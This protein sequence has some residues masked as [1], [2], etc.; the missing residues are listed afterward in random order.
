MADCG[1]A[2]KPL[3][4]FECIGYEEIGMP[5][6]LKRGRCAFVVA[7]MIGAGL[8]G[9]G[10]GGCANVDAED[11]ESLLRCHH[12]RSAGSSRAGDVY[13]R[14]EREARNRRER[15]CL[16]DKPITAG[17]CLRM[18]AAIIR[19][20]IWI[21][22]KTSSVQSVRSVSSLSRPVEADGARRRLLRRQ[23]AAIEERRR[24]IEAAE[25]AM[26]SFGSDQT[27]AHYPTGY[28]R[29]EK[30]GQMRRGR[31]IR[32]RLAGPFCRRC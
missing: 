19:S 24:S 15:V 14:C 27:G 26:T 6:V 5:C 13:A 8:L 3:K 17:S 21:A 25:G 12:L 11:H 18:S 28:E 7:A 9:G 32:S 20:A 22:S 29:V 1:P 31:L 23:N 4:R 16:G 10:R 2:G 30:H